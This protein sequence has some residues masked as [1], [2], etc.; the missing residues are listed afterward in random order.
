MQQWGKVWQPIDGN[1]YRLLGKESSGSSRFLI[2]WLH[3]KRMMNSPNLLALGG[4]GQ[5]S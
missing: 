3:G 4:L 1:H 5:G 2:K